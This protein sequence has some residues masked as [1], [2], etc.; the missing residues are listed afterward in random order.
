MRASFW[1]IGLFLAVSPAYAG[2]VAIMTGHDAHREALGVALA[3]RADVI[4]MP[5]PQGALRLDRAAAAQRAAIEAAADAAAW[6]DTGELCVVSAD[7]V[8]FRHAPLPAGESPRV[9]AAIA[10][11]LLD[12]L[13]APPEA[14]LPAIAVDV[15]VDV[16]GAA[17]PATPTPPSIAPATVT[18]TSPAPE[19]PVRADKT[20]VEIG[21]MLSPITGGVEGELALP[22]APRVRL[23]VLGFV[24]ANF[25]DGQAWIYGGG[26]EVRRA[27]LG[28]RHFDIGFAAGLA[29]TAAHPDR[30]GLVFFAARLGVTWEYARSALSWTVSPGVATGLTFNATMV[31]STS[32]IVWTSL[33]WELPL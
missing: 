32:P 23:G 25:Q 24:N 2:R 11:S 1:V 4:A 10:T 26:I 13:L 14:T 22:L 31:G 16:G 18:A 29:T 17:Q 21:P 9:F 15:H 27:G 28:R 7:G 8:Y 30:D 5:P 3:G 20:L 33:R 19:V 12:E 6:L